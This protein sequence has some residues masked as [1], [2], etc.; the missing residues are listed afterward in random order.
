MDHPSDYRLDDSGVM[1][2][3]RKG[4]KAHILEISA[5]LFMII[6]SMLFSFFLVQQGSVGFVL[7]AVSVIF[8]DAGLVFLVFYFL[9]RN[10]ESLSMI[11]WKKE[12]P[13]KEILLGAVLFFPMFYAASILEQVL[14]TAGLSSPSTPLPALQIHMNDFTIGLA[15]VMVIVVAVSEETIFRGYLMLRFG[16]T[17]GSAAAAIVI[18]SFIFSLGHGYEGSAGVVT[19]GFI[20]LVFAIIFWW[21]KN[22]LAPMVMHFLQDFIGII[23][24]GLQVK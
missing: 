13:V 3:G 16:Q 5:F 11:G 1:L 2:P 4:R 15:L 7:T 9:W 22:L 21:R 20:G 18:S 10:G 17:T 14:N 24:V 19:V 8:R 12:A 6:P 23:L